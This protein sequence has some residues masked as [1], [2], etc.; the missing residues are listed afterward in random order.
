M[1]V[2]DKAVLH[3]FDTSDMKTVLSDEQLSFDSEDIRSFLE[4][5][6]EK[7][8]RKSSA[9]PGFFHEKS[10]FFREIQDYLTND[11]FVQFSKNVAGLWFDIIRQAEGMMPSDFFICDIR[12]DDIRYL[13]FLRIGNRPAYVHRIMMQ[14]NSV[15]NEIQTQASVP[16][17]NAEEF[18]VFS[19]EKENL[20]I[21]QKKYEIDGNSFYAFAEAVLECDLKPSQQETVKAIRKAAEKVAEDFGADAVKTAASVKNAIAREIED[22]DTLDPIQLGNAVFSGRP[23]MQEAF[24]QKMQDSGFS[25][26]ERVTVDREDLMKK[27]SN[28]KL[29]TDTGIELTIPAEYFDNTEFIE[30]THSDDGSL[31]ITLKHIGSIINRP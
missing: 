15:K 8:F 20:M 22:E 24:Q 3:V 30:F 11:D 4:E 31:F 6:I 1:I 18:A 21:S 28:H 17:G 2:I 14:G 16:V 26:T 23:A 19:V 10:S 27:V 25:Q 7:C 9:K 5:N 13:V 29:K 12:K